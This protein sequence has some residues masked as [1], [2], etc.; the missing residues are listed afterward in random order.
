MKESEIRPKNIVALIP[1]RMASTRFP[2]K[3]LKKILGKPMIG[4]IYDKVKKNSL[5]KSTVVATC[6]HEIA[7]Y[8]ESIDGD[9]VM[10][11]RYHKRATDRC[12]EALE[13]LEKQN[14]TKYDI[15]VMVQGDEPMIDPAMI[16]EGL[17]PMLDDS[18]LQVTNLMGEIK[19]DI[20]FKDPN[21]VKVVCDIVGNALYFSREPIPSSHYIKNTNIFKQYGVIMFQRNFLFKYLQMNPTPLEKVESIDML[22]IIENG[23]PLKMVLSKYNIYTVDTPTELT[24]VEDMMRDLSK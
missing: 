16:S 14:N 13:K 3:P 21:V 1:A 12:A 11:G 24:Q 17:Q 20:E 6:D 5:L 10:T 8:I 2:G 18:T 19:D 7:D 22:R 23:I 4:H 9:Y 15:V